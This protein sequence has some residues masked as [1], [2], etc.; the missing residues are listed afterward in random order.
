MR[1]ACPLIPLPRASP[2]GEKKQAGS[3]CLTFNTNG[4]NQPLSNIR[5]QV[6]ETHLSRPS[7]RL[8]APDDIRHLELLRHDLQIVELIGKR[9][10]IGNGFIRNH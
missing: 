4:L 10:L 7:T 9:L 5:Q 1:R 6:E 2:G 3:D 8:R